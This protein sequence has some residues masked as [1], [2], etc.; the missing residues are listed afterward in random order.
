MCR[1]SS[2]SIW[3]VS[4]STISLS[5]A[6]TP[7]RGQ[8]RASALAGAGSGQIGSRRPSSGRRHQVLWRKLSLQSRERALPTRTDRCLVSEGQLDAT[9]DP[10]EVQCGIRA[11][12]LTEPRTRRGCYDGK[13]PT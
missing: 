8:E 13:A 12:L 5:A 2:G 11:A 4:D 6:I 9:Y 10:V 3:S 7:F 1:T